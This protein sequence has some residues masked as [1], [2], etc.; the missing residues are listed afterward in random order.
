MN[1]KRKYRLG[2]V[3]LC[4]FIV[5]MLT[6][7]A[8]ANWAATHMVVLSKE[9][10]YGV[11]NPRIDS[12]GVTAWDCIYFGHYWKNDTNG[13]GIADQRDEKEPVKWRVLSV[14]ND[15]AMGSGAE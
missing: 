6:E 14:N 4:A 3:I 13:D 10:R 2:L 7:R 12:K 5:G 11:K 15:E 1:G 8:P 9:N